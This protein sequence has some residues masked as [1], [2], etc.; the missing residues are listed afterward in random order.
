MLPALAMPSRRS[1][2]P[3]PVRV[4]VAAWYAAIDSNA[5]TDSLMSEKV[6]GFVRLKSF[7][8]VALRS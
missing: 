5:R 2:S 8:S 7:G 1:G 4:T 6:P 3:L